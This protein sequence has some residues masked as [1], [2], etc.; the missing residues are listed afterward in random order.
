MSDNF[1]FSINYSLMSNK[2]TGDEKSPW[3]HDSANTLFGGL[4][5]CITSFISWTTHY[6]KRIMRIMLIFNPALRTQT[7]PN[8]TA[9][10]YKYGIFSAK[11]ILDFYHKTHYWMGLFP[12]W[13]EWGERAG[14]G[15]IASVRPGQTCYMFQKFLSTHSCYSRYDDSWV[16]W[17]SIW[18]C[19]EVLLNLMS[20]KFTITKFHETFGSTTQKFHGILN[21]SPRVPDVN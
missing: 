4:Y 5:I 10:K 19:Q 12:T 20:L 13:I 17:I 9:Y 16:S 11:C 8:H 3:Q 18:N 15:L 2:L 1:C 7:C 21:G 14:Y 6:Q